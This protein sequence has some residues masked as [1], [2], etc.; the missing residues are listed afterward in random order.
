MFKELKFQNILKVASTKITTLCHYN[1]ITVSRYATPSDT[2]YI[3]QSTWMCSLRVTKGQNR[4]VCV[5]ACVRVCAHSVRNERNYE[6]RIDHHYTI[7]MSK[8]SNFYSYQY[9]YI[10]VYILEF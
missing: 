7:L 8:Y 10:Y 4:R 9:L 1:Y 6:L 3:T 5:C 2:T